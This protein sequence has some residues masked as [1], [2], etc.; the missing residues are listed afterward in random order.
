MITG[1]TL[2]VF[3]EDVE[4]LVWGAW[5]CIAIGAITNHIANVQMTLATPTFRGTF[6]ALL[7]GVL[8]SGGAVGLLMMMIM[9][10][11]NVGIGGIFFYWLIMYVVIW[12]VKIVFWTPVHMKANIA[13]DNEYSIYD[14]SA[15][16]T[17]LMSKSNHGKVS[18][19]AEN[20]G[21]SES[22]SY[23]MVLVD[24][25]YYLVII[26]FSVFIIR[27]QTYYGWLG[28][29]W[30]EWV[31]VDGDPDEYNQEINRFQSIVSFPFIFVGMFTGI[32][33]DFC[34]RWWRKRPGKYGEMIGISTSFTGMCIGIVISSILQAQQVEAAGYAAVI[35]YNVGRSMSILWSPL[36]IYLFPSQLFGFVFGTYEVIGQVFGLLSLPM[37]PFL[38][39]RDFFTQFGHRIILYSFVWF[40]IVLYGFVSFCI[41][42]YSFI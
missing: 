27:R 40:C 38:I 22:L 35:M 30:P 3:V 16:L 2:M 6:M 36:Y 11:T 23:K 7:A 20:A 42:M 5:P 4:L 24:A 28:S 33:L 14:H 8:G 9:E 1:F 18:P 19:E 13:N 31:A 37:T 15:T 41:H 21:K 29:G 34:S 25:N 39:G 12:F 17:W 32:W 26:A 10:S